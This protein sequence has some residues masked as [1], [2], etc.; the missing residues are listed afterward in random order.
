MND[1][2]VA[3][4]MPVAEVAVAAA[5]TLHPRP[6]PLCRSGSCARNV[7]PVVSSEGPLQPMRPRILSVVKV[8]LRPLWGRLS[9]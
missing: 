7:R 1:W 9:V 4:Q 3:R 5:E 2:L 6:S 8:P